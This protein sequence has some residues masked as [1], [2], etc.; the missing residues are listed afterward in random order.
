MP[1]YGAATYGDAFADVYD[2]W[3]E[4]LDDADFV[5]FITTHLNT[6]FAQRT[7]S[8]LELGVGTGRLLAQLISAR[9]EHDVYVG[10]DSSTAMLAVLGSRHLP[11]HVSTICCDMSRDLPLVRLILFL[12]ATTQSLTCHLS[13]PSAHVCRLLLLG[14]G[15]M[16]IL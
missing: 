1:G 14:C 6:H 4:S 5:R 11:A 12:L 7:A 10:V 13:T 9:K 16:D 15:Q 3:Y 2:E 8:V